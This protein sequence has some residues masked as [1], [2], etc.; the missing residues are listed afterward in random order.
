MA[1]FRLHLTEAQYNELAQFW[2]E[3]GREI[4]GDRTTLMLNFSE[5]IDAVEDEPVYGLSEI[6]AFLYEK[7][8][9]ERGTN[10]A[11]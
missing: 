10:E 8:Q 5:W 7:E 2:Q 3:Y 6:A 1:D 9:R 4:T 11:E